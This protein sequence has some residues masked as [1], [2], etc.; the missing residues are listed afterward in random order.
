MEI[1][2]CLQRAPVPSKQGF[3]TRH[4]FLTVNK[5]YEPF[6]GAVKSFHRV[7]AYNTAQLLLVPLFRERS[8]EGVKL[9]ETY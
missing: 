6:Y 9:T 2:V 8:M 7:A 3:A 4:P 1:T 5:S